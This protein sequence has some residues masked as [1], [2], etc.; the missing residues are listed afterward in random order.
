MANHT[1]DSGLVIII[2]WTGL[3]WENNVFPLG[4]P[5]CV[6]FYSSIRVLGLDPES[7][8]GQF[9]LIS[10]CPTFL[11]I[12]SYCV[13]LDRCEVHLSQTWCENG[14]F[15]I[16]GSIIQS[17]HQRSSCFHI[18]WDLWKR[19]WD[20]PLVPHIM[21]D[22]YSAYLPWVVI[23]VAACLS[24]HLPV[25]AFLLCDRQNYYSFGKLMSS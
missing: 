22:Q 7:N 6:D 9:I 2:V 3:M 1:K 19:E 24:S 16:L 20:L 25:K 5:C 10:S 23:A 4:L 13:K 14:I 15:K 21:A 17:K 11:T 12:G 18:A 8:Q